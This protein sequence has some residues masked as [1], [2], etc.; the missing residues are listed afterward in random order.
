MMNKWWARPVPAA[1]VIPAP[2]VEIAIIGSKE[3]VAGLISFLWKLF[4]LTGKLQEILLDLR[5][6]EAQGIVWVAVKCDN[7]YKTN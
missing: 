6:G 2:Q 4:C 3:F 5:P 1:A 7:P